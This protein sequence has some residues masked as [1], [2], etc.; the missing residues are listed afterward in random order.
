MATL[1]LSAVLASIPSYPRPV[2]ERLV[3]R[4]IDHLDEEDGDPDLEDDDPSGQCDEEGINTEAVI[5][6]EHGRRLDGPGCPISD[7]GGTDGGVIPPRGFYP[8]DQTKADWMRVGR[9]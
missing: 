1:P 5:A 6:F 3:A 9:R 2:V 8:T 7:P 4:I